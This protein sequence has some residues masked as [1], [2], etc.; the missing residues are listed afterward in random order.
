MKDYFLVL[1]PDLLLFYLINHF[2]ELF[3]KHLGTKT[4]FI[5]IV[6]LKVNFEGGRCIII[7]KLAFGI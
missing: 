4:L 7:I 2:I 5:K 6:L 3:K 1:E